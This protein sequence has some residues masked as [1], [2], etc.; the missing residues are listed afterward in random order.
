MFSPA[1]L[2]LL[3]IAYRYYYKTTQPDIVQGKITQGYWMVLA[4]GVLSSPNILYNK[5]LQKTTN[6][7]YKNNKYFV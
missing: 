3:H 4:D 6:T 7:L 2:D 1:F 5:Y